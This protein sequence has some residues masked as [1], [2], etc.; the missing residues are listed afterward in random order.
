[1]AGTAI[2]G[3]QRSGSTMSHFSCPSVEE[4]LLTMPMRRIGSPVAMTWLIT[5]MRS[6]VSPLWLT[7]TT[8]SAA[9]SDAAKR[10]RKSPGSTGT[11]SAWASSL[12]KTAPA[13]AA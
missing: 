8:T 10:P 3:P 9:R 12:K 5:S 13:S 11:I 1:M 7:A 2:S 6:F 4:T